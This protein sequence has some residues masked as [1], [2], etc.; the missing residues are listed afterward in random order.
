ME[1]K[2]FSVRIYVDLI[3]IREYIIFFKVAKLWRV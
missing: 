1:I 2:L 3:N